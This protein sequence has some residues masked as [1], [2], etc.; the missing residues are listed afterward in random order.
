MHELKLPALLSKKSLFDQVHDN[1]RTHVAHWMSLE[2]QFITKSLYSDRPVLIFIK[3][4]R[5]EICHGSSV[6]P[7]AA[8]K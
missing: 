1:I 8:S 4:V 3:P 6:Q 7:N 5:Y 2:F